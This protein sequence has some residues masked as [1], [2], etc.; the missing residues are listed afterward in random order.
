MHAG[1]VVGVPGIQYTLVSVEAGVL[2]EQGRVDVDHPPLISPHET[3]C[4]HAHESGENHQVRAVPIDRFAQGSFKSGAI[5]AL[6]GDYV[7]LDPHVPGCCDPGNSQAVA[8]HD[9]GSRGDV[10]LLTFANNRGHVGATAGYQYRKSKRAHSL[11]TTPFAPLRTSPITAAISP[12]ALSKSTA[13]CDWSFGTIAIIPIPQMQVRYISAELMRAV[14]WSHSK[15]GSRCQLLRSRTTS[16]PS[17]KTRGMLS[18]M[19]PPVMCARPSTGTCR[20]SS[21]SDFT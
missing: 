19:P 10:L 18:V 6:V 13:V 14:F 4:E 9:T 11:M 3:L 1:S 21:R 5:N 7:C 12:R 2:R 20:I 8:D 16:N 17:L 15:T